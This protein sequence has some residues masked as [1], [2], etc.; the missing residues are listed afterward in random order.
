MEGEEYLPMRGSKG[1]LSGL[2]A[3]QQQL[4]IVLYVLAQLVGHQQLALGGDMQQVDG[5]ATHLQS[6]WHIMRSPS[7]AKTISKGGETEKHACQF[8]M[9]SNPKREGVFFDFLFGSI[10][11]M[12]TNLLT[13]FSNG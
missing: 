11:E 10:G 2:L 12:I 6:T 3:C 7:A 13:A 5:L 1:S 9:Q 4:I 8:A